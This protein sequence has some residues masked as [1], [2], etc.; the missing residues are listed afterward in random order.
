MK[1]FVG[2]LLLALLYLPT[3]VQR[4]KSDRERD[5]LIGP[6]SMVTEDR[7]NAPRQR[8]DL[9]SATR[10]TYSR[11]GNLIEINAPSFGSSRTIESFERVSED[12]RLLHR[13]FIGVSDMGPVPL[14]ANPPRDKDGSELYTLRYD[15]D[16]YYRREDGGKP[17]LEATS[18]Q[19][20]LLAGGLVFRRKLYLFDAQSRLTEEIEVRAHDLIVRQTLYRYESPTARAPHYMEH[21]VDGLARY[22]VW[23]SYEFDKRGNWIKRTQV[24]E[25]PFIPS[26]PPSN[27]TYR[28]ISYY[29]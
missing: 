2:F 19:E 5:G 27:V 13:R 10:R 8:G 6:V 1:L 12:A 15:Y 3:S 23:L 28:T 11:E 26:S 14:V 25:E 21:R 4:K 18:V 7:L 24:R 16:S 22:Q 20:N 29:Q 17:T 9:G